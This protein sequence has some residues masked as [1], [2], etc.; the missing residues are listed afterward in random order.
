MVAFWYLQ[1]EISILHFIT[2][3]I[4]KKNK[5]DIILKQYACTDLSDQGCW[6]SAQIMQHVASLTLS[7]VSQ[8]LQKL[9]R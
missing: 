2:I 4:K 9:W 8:Q 7:V 3:Y 6:V 5:Y 1:S